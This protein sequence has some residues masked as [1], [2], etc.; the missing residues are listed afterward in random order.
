MTTPRTPT[1]R[2][3]ACQAPKPARH[4]LCG[5]CWTLLPTAARR[6]LNRRDGQAFARL[7]ELHRHVDRGRPLAELEITS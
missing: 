3:P 4:Y 7:R 6:A 5:S 1:S 2:C